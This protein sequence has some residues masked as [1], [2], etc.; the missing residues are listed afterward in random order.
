MNCPYGFFLKKE[1]P[2]IIENM[3]WFWDYTY[4]KEKNQSTT[5][6]DITCYF[7]SFCS[8]HSSPIL[9]SF[10]YDLGITNTLFDAFL[11]VSAM[12]N[13]L[14]IPEMPLK[15]HAK[16]LFRRSLSSLNWDL[17]FCSRKCIVLW[18]ILWEIRSHGLKQYA[19]NCWCLSSYCA[20]FSVMVVCVFQ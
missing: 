11:Q 19:F 17:T 5:V 1:S 3:W 7:T 10:S 15:H 9:M 4:M 2:L 8:I 13:T 12:C 20:N 6:P 16:H 14:G 18:V